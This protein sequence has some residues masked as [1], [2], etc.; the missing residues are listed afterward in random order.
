[1]IQTLATNAAMAFSFIILARLI[2][3]REMGILTVLSLVASLCQVVPLAFQTAATRYVADS[4]SRNERDIAASVFYQVLRAS[5]LIASF[6]GLVVYLEATTLATRLLGDGNLAVFFELLA[7]DIVV[8]AGALPVLMGAMLGL[9]KFK[10]TATIGVVSAAIR[11]SLIILI[12]L[13]LN[14]FIGLVIAWI[15]SDA[16]SALIYAT[17]VSRVFGFPKFDFPV[18]KLLDF[19]WPLFI[20]NAASFASGWFDR[21]LLLMFVPLTTLGIYNAAL[22]AQGVLTSL[23]SAMQTALF[24]A[25]STIQSSQSVKVTD[26]VRLSSRYL[27]FIGVPLALGLAAS[28]KPALTLLV[29]QAYVEGSV[30]LMILAGVFG[31]MVFGQALSPMFPALAETR[32]ALEIVIVSVAAGIGAAFLLLP[33]LGLFGACIARAFSMFVST[34]LVVVILGRR[35][36]L[37]LD[38]WAIAQSLTAGTTMA[39]AIIA[40]QILIY[41]KLLLPVYLVVGVITYL[42]MLRLLKAVRKEDID[43]VRGYLGHRMEFVASVLSKI[44]VAQ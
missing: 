7:F 17:F 25:Y 16:A 5:F 2:S 32:M 18:R 29:G 44:V 43:L 20:S 33:T 34:A 15:I 10:E 21:A 3:T 6:L 31:C 35:M 8:Y 37:R 41:N 23:V 26:A 22:T 40:M 28:A 36:V 9:Q 12:I 30:P 42:A 38:F 19:S 14:N 39:L 4:L 1:M 27:S 13:G 24:P 11:Q